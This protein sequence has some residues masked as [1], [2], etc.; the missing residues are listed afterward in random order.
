MSTVGI[1]N[2]QAA[3][4]RYLGPQGLTRQGNSIDTGR[5]R[6]SVRRGEVKIYDKQT[7]TW[8]RAWGDPH[9]HTSDG[10]KAQFHKD[11]LTIDLPPEQI[12]EIITV[13]QLQQLVE[14][15]PGPAATF[16]LQDLESAVAI[17]LCFDRVKSQHRAGSGCSAACLGP[18]QACAA[19]A[20]CRPKHTRFHL[21]ILL[22][23]P[24]AEVLDGL[25]RVRH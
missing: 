24:P 16:G 5:Y 6:I 20:E 21:R 17:N 25:T 22:P 14:T 7:N 2:T 15:A 23:R 12:E 3:L 19:I 9:L 13:G 8:V 4:R 1:N 10:D 18:A 11:N